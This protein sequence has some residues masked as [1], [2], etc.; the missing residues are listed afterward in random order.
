MRALAAIVAA[1]LQSLLESYGRF[2]GKTV[3]EDAPTDERRLRGG[4]RRLRDWLR[5]NN[6][7]PGRRTNSDRPER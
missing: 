2:I 7:G 1:I 5:A 6:V 4:G 3:A